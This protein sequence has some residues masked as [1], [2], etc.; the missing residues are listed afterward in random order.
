M[1]GYIS[2]SH[3][4]NHTGGEEEEEEK[5]IE[6]DD[7]SVAGEQTT[8]ATSSSNSNTETETTSGPH[9][10]SAETTA[11]AT[12]ALPADDKDRVEDEPQIIVSRQTA[13]IL[14]VVALVFKLIVCWFMAKLVELRKG[15]ERVGEP[16]ELPTTSTVLP[17]LRPLFRRQANCSRMKNSASKAIATMIAMKVS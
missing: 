4:G 17:I 8:T 2:D 10:D 15:I 3:I 12:P 6:N 7:Y 14:L 11:T 13:S 9:D 5:E 1:E 16:L